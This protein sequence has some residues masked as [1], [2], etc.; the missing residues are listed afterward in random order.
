M[1]IQATGS[2]QYSTVI[3]NKPGNLSPIR[4]AALVLKYLEYLIRSIHGVGLHV[5]WT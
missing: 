3:L 1:V 2:K 5:L 4:K